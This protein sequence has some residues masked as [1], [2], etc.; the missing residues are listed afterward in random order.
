MDVGAFECTRVRVARLIVPIEVREVVAEKLPVQPDVGGFLDT[1]L[2]QCD[3]FRQVALARMGKGTDLEGCGVSQLL[4]PAGDLQGL[5]ELL[6][7]HVAQALLGKTF[8][9]PSFELGKGTESTVRQR[10]A[11]KL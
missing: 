6:F 10:A 4:Q 7:A 2:E 8:G 1:A 5:I 11:S 9:S 3:G